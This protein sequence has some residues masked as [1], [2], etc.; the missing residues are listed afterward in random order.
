MLRTG[1]P[2]APLLRQQSNRAEYRRGAADQHH[3]CGPG[4]SIE[5]LS[6]EVTVH[7]RITSRDRF[8][9][10]LA[11]DRHDT[12][13]FVFQ[14]VELV[15]VAGLKDETARFAA[16]NVPVAQP[17]SGT[18]RRMGKP[19][20][21]R[22]ELFRHHLHMHLVASTVQAGVVG[23]SGITRQQ[24]SRFKSVGRRYPILNVSQWT[25]RAL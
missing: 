3:G 22:H 4:A 5:L 14:F 20:A 13:G 12:P 6:V 25:Y 15:I 21:S 1:F 7:D 17:E 2:P 11:L 24:E 18:G 16:Y 9:R 8:L 10:A 23:H 19:V